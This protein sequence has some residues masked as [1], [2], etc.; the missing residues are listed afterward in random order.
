MSIATALGFE[1]KWVSGGAINIES[2][3]RDARAFIKAERKRMAKDGPD[4]KKRVT[5]KKRAKG[6]PNLRLVKSAA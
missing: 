1:R 3:L 5:K 4:K 6:K 2:E